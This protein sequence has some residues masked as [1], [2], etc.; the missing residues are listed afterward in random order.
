[1]IWEIDDGRPVVEGLDEHG[2]PDPAY[3]AAL[4]LIRAPYGRRVMATVVEVMI[5]AVLALPGTIVGTLTMLRIAAGEDPARMLRAGELIWPIA[6]VV[7]SQA[8][9]MIFTIVQLVLQGRKGVTVGKAMFGIRSVN[10]RTLEQPR[11]WRGAVVRYLLLY[12]S[13]LVPVIGPLLV[14]A[15]SPLLDPERRGRGWLDLASAMWFV[16]VRLGLNPYDTKRMRIARKMLKTPEREEK[17]PLPS[18]ATPVDRDTPNAYVPAGRLSGGVIGAHRM[19][20]GAPPA[21]AAPTPPAPGVAPAIPAASGFAPAA[22]SGM[23]DAV[24]PP[25]TPGQLL[26]SFAPQPVAPE[27]PASAAASAQAA[28]PASAPVVAPASAPPASAPAVPTS[29]EPVP[30]AQDHPASSVRAVVVL[31][32]GER[33]DVRGA[34]LF[35]RAPAPVAGEGAVQLIQVA[36]DTRSVSKTHL[37]ILPARRGVIVLDRGSTNGSSL[38]RGG[39]ET[40]LP[41]GEPAALQA[42]DLVRFGDRTMTVERA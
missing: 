41:A 42:G 27:P 20:G 19:T 17:A 24:P 3:A 39:V 32:T 30:P 25:L 36:D 16:D 14:V 11:F 28:P 26:D 8:L 37:A 10:V 31:D 23:V 2:R 1:M 21:G 7:I 40:P 13:F 12:A 22:T 38:V 33:V 29:S 15:L 35:G 4:G 34:T 5:I 6:A 18:L 9:V